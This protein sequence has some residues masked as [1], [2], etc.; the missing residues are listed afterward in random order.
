MPFNCRHPFGLN[1]ALGTSLGIS[2]RAARSI[3]GVRG[4][5]LVTLVA[6]MS[7][8]RTTK[9]LFQWNII[10]MLQFIDPDMRL[11]L[12]LGLDKWLCKYEMSA[13]LASLS[14][15]VGWQQG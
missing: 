5:E 9:S 11:D 6:M 2:Y 3:T 7:L 14:G 4:L 10:A 13:Y 8:L 12:N 15:S 1:F